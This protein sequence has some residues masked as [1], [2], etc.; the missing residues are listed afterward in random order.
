MSGRVVVLGVDPGTLV[1]GFAIIEKSG[2]R[3]RL[4]ECG[5]VRTTAGSP[6]AD[7]LRKIHEELRSLIERHRPDEFAIESAFYGKNAQSALKL[8]HARGVSIL[9][10]TMSDIPTFEYTPR[11][12]KKAVAGNGHATKR[13]IQYMVRSILT[14]PD[15][16]MSTDTSDAIGTAICHLH[17]R[18]EKRHAGADWTTYVR[19]HPERI[20]R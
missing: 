5:T 18:T 20:H 9:A 8:G 15:A 14:L 19:N 1:T 4:L 16:R 3:M 10:A 12:I 6:L 17:R 13:Q 7:R 2:P 11:E